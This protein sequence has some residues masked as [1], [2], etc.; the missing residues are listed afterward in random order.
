M[1]LHYSMFSVSYLMSVSQKAIQKNILKIPTE[2]KVSQ[3]CSV[4]LVWR[5]L[6]DSKCAQYF[7]PI[8]F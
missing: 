6:G 4:F 1:S 7:L 5:I 2:F 3:T 8:E